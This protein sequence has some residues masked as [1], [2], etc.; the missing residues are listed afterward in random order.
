MNKIF[1]TE[2]CKPILFSTEMVKAIMRGDKTQTRRIIK[3][4]SKNG[5]YG[6]RI[7]RNKDGV[8]TKVY[9][10][11]ENGGSWDINGTPYPVNDKFQVGD[12]LWVR[13]TWQNKS[14][15]YRHDED[16]DN[17][18]IYRATG[19]YW[20]ENYIGLTWKPSIFM[21][22]EACRIFL[23]VVAVSI[24]KLHDI[25][26][27]DIKAEG[28]SYTMDYYPILF[29][30]WQELWIRINGQESWDANPYVFVYKFEKV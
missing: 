10:M 14:V 20:M 30:S 1:D 18:F 29:E 2:K 7:S 8:I 12:I 26:A 22:K 16:E 6:I 23:K 11:D 9:G 24:E 28:V 19:D 17:G 4:T 25:T 27:E 5:K 13:E 21:P 3:P 15:L